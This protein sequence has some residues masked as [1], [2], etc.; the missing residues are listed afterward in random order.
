MDGTAYIHFLN[1]INEGSMKGLVEAVHA[2]EVNK[3]ISKIYIIMSSPGGALYPA[4][5]C[6]N[7]LRSLTTELVTHNIGFVES[8]A[9]AVFLAGDTRYCSKISRYM[10]HD[11]V[12]GTQGD[13][14]DMSAL[15][16]LVAN[17]D[18]D[19]SRLASI[20][21]DRSRLTHEECMEL[22]SPIETYL[23]PQEALEK[24]IV[25]EIKDLKLSQ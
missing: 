18:I 12:V 19:V 13:R 24:G 17:A 5:H 1:N 25:H 20:V 23:S 6:Y 22:H 7:F 15:K 8:A 11:L 2:F 4:I 16:T 14:H 3:D 10:F 21:E 9:N